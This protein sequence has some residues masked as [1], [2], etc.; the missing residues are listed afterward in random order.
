[1]SIDSSRRGLIGSWR[2]STYHAENVAGL[3]VAGVGAA[4]EEPLRGLR[5]RGRLHGE[6]RRRS[7][8][9][10]HV[11]VAQPVQ[12]LAPETVRDRSETLLLSSHPCLPLHATSH[13][14]L[15]LPLL[16]RNAAVAIRGR[17]GEMRRDKAVED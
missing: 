11:L 2:R 5:P 7:V 10:H 16:Q 9:E 8:G 3:E 6:R 14:P 4:L 17:R 12:P 13:P 15:N 1:M